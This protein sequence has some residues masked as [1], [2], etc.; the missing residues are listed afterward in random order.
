MASACRR[1]P[2]EQGR[3]PCCESTGTAGTRSTIAKPV[4]DTVERSDRGVSCFEQHGAGGFETQ[5][6]RSSVRSR[7]AD[8]SLATRLT[9]AAALTF[10]AEQH[11]RAV[12]ARASVFAVRGLAERNRS[13][14]RQQH[15]PARLRAG[16]QRQ[17][18]LEMVAPGHPKCCGTPTETIANQ[19]REA[20]AIARCMQQRT[21]LQDLEAVRF[22]RELSFRRSI[23]EA[24]T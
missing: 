20:I 6:A 24:L 17:S 5:V 12:D 1:A 10:K 9:F 7:A 18:A 2:S 23:G 8:L 19:P 16:S 4:A 11:G 13:G 22:I 21:P 3:L 14:N 15:C